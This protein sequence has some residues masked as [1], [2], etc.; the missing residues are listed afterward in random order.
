MSGAEIILGL[1]AMQFASSVVEAIIETGEA[2]STATQLCSS[3]D[4][5]KDTLKEMESVYAQLQNDKPEKIKEKL[6]SITLT[7]S[8]MRKTTARRRKIN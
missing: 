1:M 2:S 8:N 7:A 4:N 5:L 3:R 6:K